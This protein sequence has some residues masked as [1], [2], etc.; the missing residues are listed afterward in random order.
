MIVIVWMMRIMDLNTVNYEVSL[1]FYCIINNSYIILL[2]VGIVSLLVNTSI[3]AT[4]PYHSPHLT[5][6]LPNLIV[7]KKL[8]LILPFIP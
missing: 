5:K 3:G 8:L 1:V 2:E 4:Y 7:K 6:I